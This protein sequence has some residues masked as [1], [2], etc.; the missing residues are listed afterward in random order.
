MEYFNLTL[1]AFSLLII[2]FTSSL[3]TFAMIHSDD[4]PQE[5]IG[6]ILHFTSIKDVLIFSQ[7]NKKNN[8]LVNNDNLWK[9]VK[10]GR[11]THINGISIETRVESRA[12]FVESY[13]AFTKLSKVPDGEKTYKE[14][15]ARACSLGEPNAISLKIKALDEKKD[16]PAADELAEEW[17][18]K[19]HVGAL[20]YIMHK[21]I[22]KEDN[23]EFVYKLLEDGFSHLTWHHKTK[24]YI[25]YL[26]YDSQDAGTEWATTKAKELLEKWVNKGCSCAIKYK[27]KCLSQGSLDSQYKEDTHAARVLIEEYAQK[28]MPKFIKC[29]IDGLA[30]GLYGYEKDVDAARDLIEQLSLENPIAIKCKIDGFL[31]GVYGYKKDLDAARELTEEAVSFGLSYGIKYKFEGLTQG[32]HGY[33]LDMEAAY[34]FAREYLYVPKTWRPMKWLSE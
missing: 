6:K 7:I 34:A 5:V 2:I 4:L 3:D 19:G 30:K 31:G 16:T 26:L 8:I 28:S 9:I 17:V 10:K 18:S 15:L 20:V 23:N 21:K 1:K 24:Y 32:T 11:I 22:A 29:K 12:T 27:A 33:S 25:E 14:L 13:I